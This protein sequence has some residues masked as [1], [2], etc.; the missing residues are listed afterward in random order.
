MP[1]QDQHPAQQGTAGRPGR[2]DQP[3]APSPAATPAHAD[4][5]RLA[6]PWTAPRLL[7]IAHAPDVSTPALLRAIEHARRLPD[8]WPADSESLC[9]DLDGAAIPDAVPDAAATE[10]AAILIEVEYPRPPRRQ[11]D[12]PAGLPSYLASFA[13]LF[14]AAFSPATRCDHCDRNHAT[15]T[16]RPDGTRQCATCWRAALIHGHRHGLHDQPVP[17]CP[18]CPLCP[19]PQS[20]D[21]PA[22]P[23][24]RT[25]GPE[26]PAR[27]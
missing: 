23:Q 6:G 13:R 24:A 18:L 3:A 11:D 21:T 22:G 12:E 25:A 19:L 1:Q 2:A 7:G 5:P 10:Q 20:L 4:H 15:T 27:E 26:A 8:W 17:G 16:V 9:Y 14:D